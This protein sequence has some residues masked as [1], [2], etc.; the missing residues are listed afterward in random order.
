MKRA[1]RNTA[2]RFPRDSPDQQL[3]SNLSAQG[4][5]EL[6]ENLA[7]LVVRKHRRQRRQ[8]PVPPPSSLS[9]FPPTS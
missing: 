1:S 8:R 6:I 5:A 9:P 3:N 7:L 4:R 2:P